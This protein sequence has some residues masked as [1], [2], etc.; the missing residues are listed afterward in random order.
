M[1]TKKS[2]IDRSVICGLLCGLALVLYIVIPIAVCKYLS[3][4]YWDH[5]DG[6][7]GALDSSTMTLNLSPRGSWEIGSPRVDLKQH[8]RALDVMYIL[9]LSGR[10]DYVSSVLIELY[11]QNGEIEK[12]D[13]IFLE[14]LQRLNGED[15]HD[16]ISRS[17]DII[18]PEIRENPELVRNWFL[19]G[20][21]YQALPLTTTLT[22]EAQVQIRECWSTLRS[23]YGWW[24]WGNMFSMMDKTMGHRVCDF[25][26]ADEPAMQNR[27]ARSSASKGDA[28]DSIPFP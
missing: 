13:R 25:D 15:A 14:A 11:A 4:D 26:F 12:R 7:F 27:K 9:H 28:V 18:W 22:E 2:S 23:R 6:R 20:R 24:L 1:S 16:L 10:S 5:Y 8:Q 17:R 19:S 3:A 21:G